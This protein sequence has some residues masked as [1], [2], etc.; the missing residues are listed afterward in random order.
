MA[1]NTNYPHSDAAALAKDKSEATF[2]EWESYWRRVIDDK[3]HNVLT[4]DEKSKDDNE[5][6]YEKDKEN[7]Q[8]NGGSESERRWIFSLRHGERIDLTYGS[9]VPFCFDEQNKYIRK[10]LNL[11][12]QLAERVGGQDSYTKDTPLTRIGCYQAYLVGEGMR[13]AGVRIRHV[14]ASAAM[15]CVQTAQA[16]LEGLEADPSIKIRVEPGLFEYK[17]WHPK[18]LAPFMTHNEFIESGCN[19]D[20]DYKPYV[21]LDVSTPETMDEFHQRNEFVMHSA[22]KDTEAEGGNIIFIGHASTLDSMWQGLRKLGQDG[23]EFPPYNVN[24]NLVK[25]PY[26]GV[27]AMRDKPWELV[28]PPCPPSINSSSARFDWTILN[29]S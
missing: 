12:L 7:K 4:A 17:M 19:V 2:K 10:D 16:F 8:K 25:V 9:W 24:K 23:A 15:R 1:G 20:T 18:G 21:D 13:L 11:P 28:E 14:Y 27:A 26:C 5:I 6:V 3:F 29:D 22:Y